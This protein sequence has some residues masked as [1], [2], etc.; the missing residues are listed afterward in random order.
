MADR[1]QTFRFKPDVADAID[2]AAKKM[3]ITRTAFLDALIRRAMNIP[4]PAPKNPLDGVDL[5]VF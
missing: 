5:T 4:K 2:K 1:T 3:G